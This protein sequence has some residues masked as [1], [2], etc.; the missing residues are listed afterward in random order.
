MITRKLILGL[1]SL[2]TVLQLNAQH[3]SLKECIR[4]AEENNT[5]VELA[6][7]SVNTRKQLFER[8]KKNIL[9][10]VDLLAGFNHL[11]D[12]LQINLGQVRDG[13]IE[14]TAQQTT[15]AAANIYQDITGNPLD[16]EIQN[17]IYQTSKDILSAV[18][19]DYNPAVT[20]QDYFSA[21][22]FLR[23]PIYMGG[24]LKAVRQLNEQQLNSGMIGL[25]N[26]RQLTAYNVALQYLQVLYFN[27]MIKKQQQKVDALIQNQKYAHELLKAEIIPPYLK[28]WADVALVQGRTLLEN[29]KL[30]KENSL[31]TL[32]RLIGMETRNMPEINEEIPEEFAESPLLTD[33][34]TGSNPDVR[35]LESKKEEANVALRVAKSANYPNIFAIG[36]YQFFRKDLPLIT[37]PWI[38]GIELKWTLFDG[39]EARSRIDA[40]ESLIEETNLLIRQKQEAVDLSLRL[41]L[42]KIESIRNQSES[43]DAARKQTY[44]TT[45]M[46]RKRMENGL[47]S[48]KDVNDALQ[49]QFESEK[50]YYTSL[51]A[52][53]TSLASYY[54]LSGEPEKITHFLK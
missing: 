15:S 53:Y 27:S 1:F 49:L 20:K 34:Y 5:S 18:Y 30:E 8:S 14:G 28:N 10:T 21:G 52:Y 4:L 12:P 6:R 13:I 7:Q 35:L 9:P 32:A 33:Q 48:V 22:L 23:Q 2:L 3:L 51:V 42:N 45:E 31:M 54:Y 43:L 36:N 17:Q 25:E 41:A 40:A 16:S 37:P 46:V 44:V 50:L 11:S 19:P 47:S 39:F 38:V 29:L 26:T 24:K